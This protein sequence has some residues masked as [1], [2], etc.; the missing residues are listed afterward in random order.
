MKRLR[1]V[2]RLI[3]KALQNAILF[4]ASHCKGSHVTLRDDSPTFLQRLVFLLIKN[5]N[6]PCLK[7]V[8]LG[9][10]PA[11]GLL[12]FGEKV[13]YNRPNRLRFVLPISS[14]VIIPLGSFG[15]ILL[16][17][18]M[19]QLCMVRKMSEKSKEVLSRDSSHDLNGCK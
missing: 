19:A 18:F 10:I 4:T 2:Y 16:F 11:V 9:Q 5:L 3:A 13:R 17:A 6:H 1:F 12:P 7:K 15:I 8:L 14:H